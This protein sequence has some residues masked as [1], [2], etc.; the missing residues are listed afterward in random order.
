MVLK[1]LPVFAGSQK[2]FEVKQNVPSA[3]FQGRGSE[4]FTRAAL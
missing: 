3:I 1:M 2:Q 4:T